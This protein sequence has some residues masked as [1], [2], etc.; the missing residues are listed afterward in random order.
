ME[1]RG[2]RVRQ[3]PVELRIL[4]L[5]RTEADQH[6]YLVMVPS[7][8]HRFRKLGVFEGWV[9]GRLHPRLTGFLPPVGGPVRVGEERGLS[10][11]GRSGRNWSKVS[12]VK[13]HIVW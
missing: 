13:L 6:F 11:C 4:L 9:E 12:G 1:Q 3:P 10:E 5:C 8:E 7:V 2:I